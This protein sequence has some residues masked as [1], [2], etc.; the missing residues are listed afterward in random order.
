[1]TKHYCKFAYWKIF[2]IIVVREKN[3]QKNNNTKSHVNCHYHAPVH[4]Q[5]RVIMVW[6]FV[7]SCGIA[8]CRYEK[9]KSKG[10]DTCDRPS[11]LTQIGFKS[12][13]FR[14]VR[15]WNLMDDL[16]KKRQGSSS[17]LRQALW[18][19][20][21]PAVNSNWSYNPEPLNSGQNLIF[22]VPCDLEIWWMT[23]KNNRSPLLRQI[24]LCASFDHHLWI[25]TGVTV[26]KRLNWVLT[27]VTM[28]FDLWPSSLLSIVITPDI[29][30]MIRW[31]EHCKK[32]V[33]DG[34]TD[35]RKCY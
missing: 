35:G 9:F 11:I 24:K 32:G 20:S 4:W 1:M 29:F 28:T 7:V 10:F 6:N 13:I 30:M 33:K 31:Q 12:S 21:K 25:Q 5:L 22:F 34:R 18:I 16:K 19:I 2:V 3:P 26:R 23:L 15:P 8:S 17:I 27:S 14:P